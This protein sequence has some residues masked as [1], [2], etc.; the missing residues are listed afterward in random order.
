MNDER[1]YIGYDGRKR[2]VGGEVRNM[3]DRTPGDIAC[4]K[5]GKVILSAERAKSYRERDINEI[6]AG[7]TCG[8]EE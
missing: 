3:Q 2:Y 7:H 6:V 5:C 1:Y 4:S 8:T